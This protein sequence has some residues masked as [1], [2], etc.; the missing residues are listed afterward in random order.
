MCIIYLLFNRVKRKDIQAKIY[1]KS[2]K[3]SQL[4]RLTSICIV[5]IFNS[6][7]FKHMCV[8]FFQYKIQ[9]KFCDLL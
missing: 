8:R 2:L 7:K 9:N 6:F 5:G 3:T 1:F 4:K